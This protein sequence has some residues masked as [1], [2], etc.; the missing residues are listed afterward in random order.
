VSAPSHAAERA[1]S[2]SGSSSG[3]EEL[4]WGRTPAHQRSGLAL[5]AVAIAENVVIMLLLSATVLTILAQIVFR[6]FLDQPLSWSTE[7]A[8]QLLVYVAFVGFAIG[9]RDNVHVAMRA[10]ENRFSTTV[11]RGLRVIEL[12]VLG[13]VVAAIGIGGAIYAYEQRDVITPAGLPLWSAFAALPL[14]CALGLLHVLVELV[15][16]L[17]GTVEPADLAAQPTV[18]GAA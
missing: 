12:L 1:S 2:G 16:V 10:F 11:Q 6:R 7:V 8:T 14:G 9:V 4:E 17:R 3:V 18:W 5:N 13:A 15:A